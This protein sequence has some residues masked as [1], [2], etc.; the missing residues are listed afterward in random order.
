MQN[1]LLMHKTT[2]HICNDNFQDIIRILDTKFESKIH[3]LTEQVN[4]IQCTV[5]TIENDQMFSDDESDNDSETAE[6]DPDESDVDETESED[7]QEVLVEKP[8]NVQSESMF[9]KKE[10]N[11]YIKTAD[12]VFLNETTGEELT[13]DDENLESIGECFNI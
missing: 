8:K 3:K 9:I 7:E 13:L 12:N 4:D 1:Q 11:K 5:A 6:I 10:K 2:F